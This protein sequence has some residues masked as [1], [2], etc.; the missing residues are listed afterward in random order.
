MWR[1]GTQ[2]VSSRT[3]WTALYTSIVNFHYKN[4]KTPQETFSKKVDEYE[5]METLHLPLIL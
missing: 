5:Y 4:T 1:N 2:K 3:V